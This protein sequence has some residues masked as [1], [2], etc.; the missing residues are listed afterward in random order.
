MSY[1]YGYGSSSSRK[2]TDKKKK[3]NR[4]ALKKATAYIII[5]IILYP[6][7][8]S[9]ITH[10][11]ISLMGYLKKN[12]FGTTMI[13]F[14]SL[15]GAY[16]GALI[17]GHNDAFSNEEKIGKYFLIFM[18]AMAIFG[19]YIPN[20]FSGGVNSRTTTEFIWF[21]SYTLAT[22]TGVFLTYPKKADKV[23]LGAVAS[24][25]GFIVLFGINGVLP[26]KFKFL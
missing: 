23:K 18:I 5:G 9:Y 1:Y 2:K 16:F 21:I 7:I 13:G 24:V 10:S 26:A 11:Q 8:T 14:S 22:Y 6:L 19:T 20:M 12:I 25:I 15:I 17:G 3:T 4:K